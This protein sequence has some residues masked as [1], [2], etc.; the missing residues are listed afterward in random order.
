[1]TKTW[2][3]S[4]FELRLRRYSSSDS[5]AIPSMS[6]DVEVAIRHL[7]QQLWSKL[8]ARGREAAA[9]AGLR[10]PAD[11][12][13]QRPV[14]VVLFLAHPASKSGGLDYHRSDHPNGLIWWDGERPV[15]SGEHELRDCEKLMLELL[16]MLVTLLRSHFADVRIEVHDFCTTRPQSGSTMAGQLRPFPIAGAGR[17]P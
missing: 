10:A 14:R 8:T 9:A 12:R 4:L 13:S 6:H 7:E 15:I 17:V 16:L 2:T 1:M 11:D 5:V 3:P